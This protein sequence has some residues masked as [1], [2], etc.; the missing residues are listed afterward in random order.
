MQIN[1]QWEDAPDILT[2]REA[3]K[4][5]RIGKNQMYELCRINDFP[6]VTIGRNIRIP[7]EA[8]RHWLDKQAENKVII[9]VG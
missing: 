4:L 8:L 6:Q 2:V 9:K 3:A 5:V 7:K 1:M